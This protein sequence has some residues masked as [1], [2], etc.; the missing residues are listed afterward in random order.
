MR[1]GSALVCFVMPE[2]LVGGGGVQDKEIELGGHLPRYARVDIVHVGARL[3]EEAEAAA[4]LHQEQVAARGAELH[5]GLARA[6]QEEK[7]RR[8]VWW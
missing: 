3:A 8:S 7:N 4:L 1:V 5:V 6:P 2:E